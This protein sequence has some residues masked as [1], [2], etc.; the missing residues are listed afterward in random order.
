MDMAVAEKGLLVLD[1]TSHGTS[2]H[3]ARNEG[4]N[5]IYKALQ[6]IDWFRSYSFP[7]S[8]SLLGDCK[9]SVTVI[10]AGL[11]HNVVPDTCNFTVDIRVNDCYTHEEILDI[12]RQHVACDVE[13]RSLRLRS[14]R[15]D[16]SHPLVQ[17]GKVLGKKCFGSATLSDKALMPFPALKMGPGDSMRSHTADEFIHLSEI[18]EGIT[19]YIA[20]LK[21][22]L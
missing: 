20:L 14:T 12:V 22:L 9:M 4:V 19:T 10:N 8:S 13:P 1:C 3:A 6:D 18:E 11:Q 2:G 21:Q 16:E 5:A 17:A 7:K 15:I